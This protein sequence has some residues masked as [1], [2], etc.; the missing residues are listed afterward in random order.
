MTSRGQDFNRIRAAIGPQAI[1]SDSYV[2]VAQGDSLA[3]LRKFPSHSVSLVLTDPPYHATKKGNIYG[4]T[5]FVRDRQYLDWM[6]EFA[7]EW[8]RVLRPNGS[9]FCFCDSSMAG[10]LEVLFSKDFNILSHIV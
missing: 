8:R 10:R 9:L 5:A 1:L 7:T 2:L 3:L 4:D 6:G